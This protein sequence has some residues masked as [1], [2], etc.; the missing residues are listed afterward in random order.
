MV[1]TRRVRSGRGAR[2]VRPAY[3]GG[4]ARQCT[5]RLRYGFP[6]MRTAKGRERDGKAVRRGGVHGVGGQGVTNPR[7]SPVRPS[8]CL[9][10]LGA[11]PGMPGNAKAPA[12][13]CGG[14][15]C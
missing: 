11:F 8:V 1:S 14:G 4:G 15:F 2:Q 13:V 9:V 5:G 7:R 10:R 6:V 12:T 3:P